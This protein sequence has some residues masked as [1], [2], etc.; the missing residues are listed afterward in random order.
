MSNI[1]LAI[2]SLI[3]TPFVTFVAILSL[4]LGIGATS[5]IFSLFNQLFLRPFRFQNL[6]ASSTS[7]LQGQSQDRTL[8]ASRAIAIAFSVF[9]CS[10]ILRRL[11]P[12]LPE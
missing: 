2:R 1:R 7:E 12:S 10:A 11:R 8:V 4:A 3:K 6:R 5:A 9:R